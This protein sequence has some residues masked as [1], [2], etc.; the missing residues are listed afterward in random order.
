MCFSNAVCV[1]V[2]WKHIWN[3]WLGMSHLTIGDFSVYMCEWAGTACTGEAPVTATVDSKHNWISWQISWC[4]IKSIASR[5]SQRKLLLKSGMPL[6][7]GIG[8]GRF[9]AAVIWD[10]KMLG[11]ILAVPWGPGEFRSLILPIGNLMYF[12]FCDSDH[13]VLWTCHLPARLSWRDKLPCFGLLAGICHASCQQTSAV[14]NLPL[15][16]LMSSL[17]SLFKG[18][19]VHLLPKIYYY[20]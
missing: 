7:A 9:K 4:W 14:S 20:I 12:G 13:L 10:Y 17:L 18:K 8:F 3:R 11:Q 2:Y 6:F 15:K 16:L 5:I 19:N 1:S